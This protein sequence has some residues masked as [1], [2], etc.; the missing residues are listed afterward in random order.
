MYTS[1]GA[2]QKQAQ[3]VLSQ[4]QEHPEAWQRVPAI[5]QGSGNGQTKV[6]R[7]RFS[8]VWRREEIRKSPVLRKNEKL[9][10]L[11]VLLR[12]KRVESVLLEYESL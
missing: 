9:L 8:K 7:E 11:D 5:L 1:T 2:E 12:K 3:T 4:F 6:S 10:S